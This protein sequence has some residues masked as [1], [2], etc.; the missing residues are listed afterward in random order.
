MALGGLAVMAEPATQ[1]TTTTL[2]A[3]MRAASLL[4]L[5]AAWTVALGLVG[6][7]VATLIAAPLA[8]ALFGQRRAS[9]LALF[10]L[11]VPVALH[12]F[13]FHVLGVFPPYGRLFDLADIRLF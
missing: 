4:L 11:L 1:D 9:P 13:F 2:R 8:F 10:A 12:L 6:F 7:L 3:E 5:G